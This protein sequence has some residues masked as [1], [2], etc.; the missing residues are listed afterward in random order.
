MDLK[1]LVIKLNEYE[2][3]NNIEEL[4]NL[5]YNY[6]SFD[7]K[8][9]ITFS[10]NTYNKLFLHTSDNFDLILICWKKGQ[11]TQIHD[12]PD[13]CCLLKMLEGKLL[14]EE[15]LNI[16]NNL[17]INQINI[18]ENNMIVNKKQDKILH[19]IIAQ[20][21]SVSLHLYIPGF[22]KPKYY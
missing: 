13:F 7:Y 16:D 22:Y 19:K 8:D 4:Y 10:E 18:L 20:E 14:E 5:L 15:Y 9:L 21:D 6:N 3:F 11:Y 2:N 1:N 17:Q 12:H